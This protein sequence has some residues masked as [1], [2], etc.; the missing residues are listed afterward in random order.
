MWIPGSL[1]AVNVSTPTECATQ[2]QPCC[3]EG[4][5]SERSLRTHSYNLEN[6]EKG[7]H[8][9]AQHPCNPKLDL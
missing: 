4:P 3:S 7:K 6:A 8:A 1:P 5:E 9:K 2:A